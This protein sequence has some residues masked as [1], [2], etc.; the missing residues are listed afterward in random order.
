MRRKIIP[1][2]TD[3]LKELLQLP[4]STQITGIQSDMIA[5]EC[6]LQIEDPSF[7][8]VPSGT[9][10]DRVSAVY[11]TLTHSYNETRFARWSDQK[12]VT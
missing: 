3:M 6:L 4:A 10:P 1:L 11:Q 8:D 5:N 12:A 9:V 2:S 7:E